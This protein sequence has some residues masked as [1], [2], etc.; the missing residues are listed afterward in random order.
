M[1]PR[2]GRF[3]RTD[4]QNDMVLSTRSR[5][6]QKLGRATRRQ[7]EFVRHGYMHGVRETKTAVV[8]KKAMNLHGPKREVWR[9]A[10]LTAKPH[11][12]HAQH[13]PVLRQS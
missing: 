5:S 2:G 4:A 3:K 8:E 1:P 9:I 7:L 12:R 11:V 13:L 6:N 10:W